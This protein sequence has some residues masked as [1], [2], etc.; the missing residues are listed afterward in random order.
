MA[1]APTIRLA[2]SGA[3]GAAKLPGA[4][5]APTMALPKA[6]VQLQA[7]TQPL[8]TSFSTPSQMGTVKSEEEEE[9]EGGGEGL[10]NVLSIVGFV[11]ALVVLAFQLMT[12]GTWIKAEDN[13]NVGQWSQL[14][15]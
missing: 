15:E 10:A 1:P 13:P 2:T 3:P 9:E 7:P 5:G 8:G 11:A 6:T 14:M 4:A 12:A